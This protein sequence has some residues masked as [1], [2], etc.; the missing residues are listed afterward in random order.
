MIKKIG[1]LAAS[2]ALIALA[3]VTLAVGEEKFS[4][5]LLDVACAG[6]MAGNVDKAKA[7]KKS[8]ALMENCQK[9]GFGIVTS[10]GKLLKFD[11][12]GNKQALE[13][14]NKTSKESDIV[15]EVTGTKD[16][17]TLKVSKLTEKK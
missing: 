2:V 7:H 15:V 1:L 13:L 4:G 12:N 6:R 3:Q 17:D 8:C 14:L 5:N 10:D 16:G 9:S 11:E